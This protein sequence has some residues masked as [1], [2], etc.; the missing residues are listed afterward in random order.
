M[1]PCRGPMALIFDR[2]CQ[3][4]VGKDPVNEVEALVTCL[5]S[6]PGRRLKA[7][8]GKDRPK[9]KVWMPK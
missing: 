3:L 8:S 6:G 7:L 9:G 5:S 1:N 2:Y 4:R